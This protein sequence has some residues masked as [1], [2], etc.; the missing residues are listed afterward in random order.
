MDE[1]GIRMNEKQT[2][3][4]YDSNYIKITKN[5]RGYGWDIKLTESGNKELLSKMVKDIKLIDGELQNIFG[6]RQ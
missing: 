4:Q 6:D 3:S 2:I 1:E 5:T